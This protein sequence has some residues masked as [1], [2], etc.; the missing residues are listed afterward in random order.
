M[1]AGFA[2]TSVIRVF[3]AVLISIRRRNAVRAHGVV[4]LCLFTVKRA[5]IERC[6]RAVRRVE[7]VAAAIHC[8]ARSRRPAAGAQTRARRRNGQV[9]S[10]EVRVLQRFMAYR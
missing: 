1:E 9:A 6:A 3:E 10:G 7:T 5:S 8:R 2:N 4:D